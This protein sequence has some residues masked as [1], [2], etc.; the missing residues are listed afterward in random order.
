MKER[1]LTLALCLAAATAARTEERDPRLPLRGW[2]V[3][4]SCELSGTTPEAI[5]TVGYAA[6]GWHH[7]DAPE[8]VVAALV[9][10][11]TLPDP[12][13]GLNLKSFPGMNYSPKMFFA[14]EDMPEGSPFRCSFF[15]RAEWLQPA[16]DKGREVALHFLGINYRAN[17]WV[18]GHKVA[19]AATTAGT[20]RSFE[21]RVTDLVHAGEKNAVA[22]EISAPG[23]NDLGITWVDWNPTPPDKNM[24][25]WK[26]AYLS[27]SG[28]V[29]LRRPFVLSHLAPGYESATV[30]PSADLRNLGATPVEGTL[31]AEVGE[32]RVEKKIA[33]GPHEEKTVRLEAAEFAELNWKKPRLWWPYQMGEPF[34]YKATLSF[35]IGG[36]VSD[37]AS[38][39]FGIREV[40]SEVAEGHRLFHVNGRK[41]LVAGAAWAPD[42]LLRWSD[43]RVDSDLAYVKDM[44]LNAIRLEG[45]LDREAFYTK[46]DRLG[47]LVMPGWTCCDAWEKWARWG[48]EQKEVARE[49]MRDQIAILRNHP[50]VFVFLYGSDN[51]P[52][53]P[54]ETMYLG[55]LKDL[56][57]PNPSVSSASEQPTTVTGSSGVKMTG[58]Y[59]YV[60]PVYWLTDKE[61]GGAHGYNTETSPGPAIPPRESLERF[62]GKD[63]LWPM[64]AV[65]NF[66]AGLE[67]FTDVSVFTDG[68]TKRYGPATSLDDYLRKAQA[69]AYD[70]ERSMFEAYIRNRYTSTGVIQWMLDNAWPSLIWHLYDYYRVPTGGYFGTKKACELVHVLYD[71]GARSVVASNRTN[72]AR[73]AVVVTARFY[74]IDGEPRGEQT[75]TLDLPADSAVAVFPATLDGFQPGTYFLRLRLEEQGKVASENVYWLST[76]PDTLDWKARKDTVYTPQA[77][78]ADLTGLQGLKTVALEARAGLE[79]SNRLRVTLHN[80]G[81]APAFMAHVRVT[82]GKGGE[83][84]TPIFW[85][86]NYVFLLP[87]ESRELVATFDP[88]RAG[89]A[90]PV[91]ELDGFNVAPATLNP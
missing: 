66:H 26:E 77:T 4:S 27:T 37:S 70:N 49:S 74:G 89:G 73:E 50:S 24:G 25:L 22:L 12:N 52:P 90:S 61:A 1:I 18:N 17:V 46:A 3:R 85:Q 69:M 6:T 10:D 86:D 32:T 72:E 55:V 65:W 45:R 57:W 2:D 62:L 34:L 15:Y 43:E 41:L 71:Y 29:A 23:K 47:L 51:P 28:Q 68:L 38:L 91:V 33:L 48:A 42:L 13:V 60:P 8:T 11:K 84:L 21:F 31:R 20:Y 36:K 80:T 59:E 78:F 39:E 63:H 7:S 16:E 81:T 19:D 30:E 5:S 82:K 9:G 56:R 75:K 14:L 87:G 58:P 67:R 44:N 35:E 79:S 40:T 54:I 76:K 64:D 53:P 83:D 88:A